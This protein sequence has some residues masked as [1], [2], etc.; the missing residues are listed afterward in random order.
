MHPYNRLGRLVV[1]VALAIAGYGLSILTLDEEGVK[2]ESTMA[3]MATYNVTIM[4]VVVH[5]VAR[6]AAMCKCFVEGDVAYNTLGPG[7]KFCGKAVGQV[8]LFYVVCFAGV[9]LAAGYFNGAV[10]GV[11][12]DKARDTFLWS[13]LYSAILG[14][15]SSF[16]LFCFYWYGCC[17]CD[18]CSYCCGNGQ[19]AHHLGRTPCRIA[20]IYPY[21]TEYPTDLEMMWEGDRCGGYNEGTDG[22]AQ[23]PAQPEASALSVDGATAEEGAGLGTD[24]IVVEEGMATE[25]AQAKPCQNNCGRSAYGSF[26]TCCT[27][28]TGPEGPHAKDCYQKTMSLAPEKF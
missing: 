13:Q 6:H 27:R 26:T 18:C 3:Q 20:A 21:G 16:C 17:C 28:C 22:P 8:I 14:V 1:F 5:Y 7:A 19:G 2:Q 24:A 25:Q 11:N 23:R 15:F 9:C 12:M 10:R 4:L